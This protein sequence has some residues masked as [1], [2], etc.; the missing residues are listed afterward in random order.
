MSSDFQT[1]YR[2][3]VINKGRLVD[4]T[5]EG[6]ARAIYD[7]MRDDFEG[8]EDVDGELHSLEIEH[9]KTEEENSALQK[10]VLKLEERIKELENEVF[11]LEQKQDE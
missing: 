2:N 8:F 5:P 11:G 6:H 3:E 4:N 7:H 1:I 10:E 9:E